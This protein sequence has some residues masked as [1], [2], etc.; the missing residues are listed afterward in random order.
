MSATVSGRYHEPYSGRASASAPD[1]AAIIFFVMDRVWP[2]VQRRDT[3][4]TD[5]TAGRRRGYADLPAC[6]AGRGSLRKEGR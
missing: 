2:L 3:T 6:R 5:V 1:R 4:V